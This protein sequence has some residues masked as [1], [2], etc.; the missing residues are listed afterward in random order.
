MMGELKQGD[1]AWKL[2]N[3]EFQATGT[4]S[5]MRPE[6]KSIS[7]E[8]YG[9]R[10]M[11]GFL[12]ARPLWFTTR[13]GIEQTT[14][15]RI[16][17]FV[18]P[19]TIAENTA[20]SRLLRSVNI[21]ERR[22][23][24]SEKGRG[25]VG[26]VNGDGPRKRERQ[27]ELASIAGLRSLAGL[28]TTAI[29]VVSTW[30]HVGPAIVYNLEVEDTHEY[31]AN[32]VL[33]HNCLWADELAAWDKMQESWDMLMFGL[34]LGQKPQACI[35]TT[36]KPV[37][38]IIDLLKDP[39]TA[40][41]R[42]TTYDNRENLAPEFFES[43][44]LKYEGTRLGRQELDAEVLLDHPGALWKL[45]NIEALRI[46]EIPD[47]LTRIVVGVDPAVTANKDSDETGIVVAG[48]GPCCC[49]GH[50]EL[51]GFV[52]ADGS[53]IHTPAAWAK[54]V[55]A[56]YRRWSADRVIGEANNGGDLVEAN[57]RTEDKNISYKAVHASRG[58]A[59]RAEPISALYEQ[60]K[61]HHVGC[62]PRL[63]D[64]MT[65]WDPMQKGQ[66]SPDRLDAL[67]WACSELMI[68]GKAPHADLELP[69][70]SQLNPWAGL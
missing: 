19:E 37:P 18:R 31:F 14:E 16:S 56:L 52:L 36:P 70:L 15:L 60:G 21:A 30:E 48:I 32:G 66:K 13:M 43:I 53:G 69:E 40:V 3:G 58:K 6:E 27:R 39:R 50:Q 11:G 44:I 28:E 34:R 20:T 42:G 22:S 9:N 64:Q 5:S 51:H 62:F 65:T 46:R 4:S 17:R 25:F 49:K 59:A 47:E 23:K 35:T 10:R 55:V 7:I 2:A 29:S 57:V 12:P 38:L 67:V 26:P 41:T 1:V 45:G 61:I 33:V 8:Q 24:E 68:S 54:E 63:E